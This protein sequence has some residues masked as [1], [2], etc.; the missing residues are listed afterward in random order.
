M[1]FRHETFSPISMS[2]TQPHLSFKE[3]KMFLHPEA[4][5]LYEMIDDDKARL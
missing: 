2:S 3:M 5:K 4:S 1:D